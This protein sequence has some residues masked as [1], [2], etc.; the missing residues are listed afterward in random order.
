LNALKDFVFTI[1]AERDSC[2]ELYF[3]QD[4]TP[5]NVATPDRRFGEFAHF[6]SQ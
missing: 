6:L 3:T 5:Q 4:G 2:E 1:V